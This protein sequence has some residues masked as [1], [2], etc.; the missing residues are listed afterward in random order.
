MSGHG[1]AQS[2]PPGHGYAQTALPQPAYASPVYP[3]QPSQ[4][5]S[6]PGEWAGAPQPGEWAGHRQP[7]EWAGYKDSPPYSY[8]S[9]MSAGEAP[10]VGWVIAGTALIGVLGAFIAASQAKKAAAVGVSGR[11]YWIAF[12]VTLGVGWILGIVLTGVLLVIA[13]RGPQVTPE[14]LEK[15]IVAQAEVTNED[16]DLVTATDANCVA[17]AVDSRG[18]GT[19]QCVVRF[20]DGARASY[21]ITANAEGGWISSAGK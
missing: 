21:E 2:G 18:A 15:S 11:K 20:E 4:S 5:Y 17:V 12:G 10:G 6:R 19:Y 1:Y 9:V 8:R 13:A 3:G 14:S 16:G 7:G